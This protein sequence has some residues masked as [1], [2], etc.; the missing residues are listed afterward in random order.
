MCKFILIYL[1]LDAYGLLLNH[2]DWFQMWAKNN[3]NIYKFLTKPSRSKLV[4]KFNYYLLLN[5]F[6]FIHIHV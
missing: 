5:Y 3:N 6:I 4:D 2:A 1:D